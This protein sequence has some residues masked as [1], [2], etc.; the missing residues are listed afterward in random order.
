[1]WHFIDKQ[2]IYPSGF[3]VTAAAA[4][5]AEWLCFFLSVASTTTQGMKWVHSFISS[6]IEMWKKIEMAQGCLLD[7][8]TGQPWFL[9]SGDFG[10]RQ[11]CIVNKETN[12]GQKK[13]NKHVSELSLHQ[14][15]SCLYFAVLWAAIFFIVIILLPTTT[16]TSWWWV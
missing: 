9:F 12:R 15:Q 4:E 13:I 16:F 10:S 6:M 7:C 11:N 8:T 5:T 1:M 2:W 14:R 3:T